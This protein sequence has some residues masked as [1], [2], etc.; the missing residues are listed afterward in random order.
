MR[1]NLQFAVAFRHAVSSIAN[2]IEPAIRICWPW[3]AIV[4][5]LS[6]LIYALLA[7]ATGG[8]PDSQPLLSF[9]A[10]LLVAAIALLSASSIAV[11]W[12]N[13]ILRDE[14]PRGSKVLRLDDR[15]WRYFGNMLMIM[16]SVLAVLLIFA[17]PLSFIALLANSPALAVAS[18]FIVGVPIAGTMFL[19]LAVKLPNGTKPIIAAA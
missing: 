2:N 14:L 9:F 10:T 12:H 7:S 5:P 11:N 1:R 15:V 8:N 17:I 18:T 6:L 4:I 3:Y 13:Y 19:R 16:L